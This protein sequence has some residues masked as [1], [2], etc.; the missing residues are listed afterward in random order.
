MASHIYVA[1]EKDASV[2]KSDIYEALRAIGRDQL[3]QKSPVTA[4]LNEATVGT[5]EQSFSVTVEGHSGEWSRSSQDA[6]LKALINI[7]GVDGD[8]VEVVSGGYEAQERYSQEADGAP[9]TEEDGAEED[10]E[11]D[12]DDVSEIDGVG[13]ARAEQLKEAGIETTSDV[14]NVGVS[15]LVEAGISEGVAENIVERA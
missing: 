10:D 14:L 8:S 12:G 4:Q 9:V 6:L 2:S 15:G 5:R 3:S 13:P 7:D 11:P 1:G